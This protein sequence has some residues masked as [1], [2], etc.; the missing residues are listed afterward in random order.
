MNCAA[1]WRGA[2]FNAAARAVV[3]AM[4]AA[5]APW[6]AGPASAQDLEFRPPRP[7]IFVPGLMGSRLCRE[8]PA[9]PGK[10]KVVWGTVGALREFPNIRLPR[11]AGVSDGIRPCGL[12]REIAV[13]GGLR[14]H[15]YG[16][17]IQHLESIG[18]RE[19]RDLFAFDY[20]WRRSAL[21]NARA[22]DFFIQA[23]AGDRPVDILAHS[24]G[25]IVARIYTVEYGVGRVARLFSAGAPYLG[26]AKV[27]QTMEK[28]WGTLN[29]AM[30]GL[31]GFRRTMLSFPSIFEVMARYEGCCVNGAEHFQPSAAESWV[32]LG[33]EGVDPAAMPDLVSTFDRIRLIN[34]LIAAPLPVD[35]EEVLLIGV[36]Q[37]TTRRVIFE[38]GGKAVALR[39]QTSWAGD[40][41]VLRDS[42]I[43]PRR[44]THPTSFAI[45]ERILLD[46]QIQDFLKVALIKGVAAAID[47][48]PVRP[49][50]AVASITGEVTELVGIVVETAEPAYTTGDKGVVRVHVRL[51]APVQLPPKT[52]RLSHTMPD[53]SEGVIP[54]AADPSASEPGNPFE[55][56]FVGTFPTG[57][58]PGLGRLRAVVTLDK[59]PPRIVDEPVLVVAR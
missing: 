41:T 5:L 11:D 19:G 12:L 42:A 17:V 50:G 33:W 24:M 25:G 31:S 7:L 54:L 21:D 37:R 51:G 32:A 49:R 46:P 48:V 22:L 15:Y 35:I 57:S 53:G 23:K 2:I 30:G 9:D 38:R 55:L 56:S 1:N 26:A 27:F 43:L 36:D 58:A 13:L 14:Q 45:H 4:F 6:T 3:G 52:I 40:G 34:R 29:V 18:Y 8:N 59:A 44:V 16:P 28:G 10:P 47:G 20:D 39:V